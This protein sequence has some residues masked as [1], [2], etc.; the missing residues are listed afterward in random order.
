MLH[1]CVWNSSKGPAKYIVLPPGSFD[2][3]LLVL[4]AYALAVADC[5]PEDLV[6]EIFN[7]NFL[8]KL[9]S[10]LESTLSNYIR[11]A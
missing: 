5:F 7:V 6:R 3:H 11:N 1:F 8:A 9:D 10:Q 2:P 4:L